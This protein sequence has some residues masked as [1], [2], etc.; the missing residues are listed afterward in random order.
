MRDL[1]AQQGRFIA[2]QSVLIQELSSKVA[3]SKGQ[4]TPN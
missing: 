4:F 3:V 1:I 2:E